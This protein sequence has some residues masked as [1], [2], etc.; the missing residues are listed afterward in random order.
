MSSLFFS[1]LL[2]LSPNLSHQ[3]PPFFSLSIHPSQIDE[4]PAPSPTH[5]HLP[6]FLPHGL[7]RHCRPL[8]VNRLLSALIAQTGHLVIVINRPYS[9]P[10]VFPRLLPRL[11]LQPRLLLPLRYHHLLL[12]QSLPGFFLPLWLNILRRHQHLRL[13]LQMIASSPIIINASTGSSL[14]TQLLLRVSYRYL[15]LPRCFHPSALFVIL[16]PSQN[17]NRLC[18]P[19]HPSSELHLALPILRRTSTNNPALRI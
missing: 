18:L 9:L 4:V 12:Q 6:P 17:G 8:P 10:G 7:P 16:L 3:Q 13:F 19:Y 1:I 14:R 2:N 11:R 5:L 15:R